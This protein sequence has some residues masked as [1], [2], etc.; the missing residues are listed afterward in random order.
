[1]RLAPPVVVGLALLLPG[2]LGGDSEEPI[3]APVKVSPVEEDPERDPGA[4][5]VIAVIEEAAGTRN[6]DDCDRLATLA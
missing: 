3:P 6:G 1:V 5:G 2:C 4:E